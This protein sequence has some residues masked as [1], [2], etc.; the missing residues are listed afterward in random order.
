MEKYVLRCVLC[1]KEYDDDS[2]RL[3]CD[4][5]HEPSLLRTEYSKKDLSLKEDL[6][7]MF[8]FSDYLP[9]DRVL[10]CKGA[11]V[12][13]RSEGI[14]AELGLRNLHIIFNGYWPEKGAFMETASFKELE[15][16]AVLA[17]VPEGHDRTIVVAS[18]GNTGR[19]FANICS[20]NRIPLV[21][22]IPEKNA[23]Q[24]WGTEPF[25]DTVKL[26]LASGNSD[27]CD[28]ITLAG[29]LVDLNGFFAEGGALNVARRDGMATTI[30]DFATTVGAAPMHYFQAIGSGTG[31]IAAWESYLR[32]IDDGGYGDGSMKLHLSQNHPFVPITEA[33]DKGMETMPSLDPDT[34]KLQIKQTSAKVLTN[35]K[36]PYSVRGGVY[37]V[38][39]ASS[40]HTYSVTNE[41]VRNALSMFA[42]Y[43]GIDI[44]PAAGVAVGSLVQAVGR[45]LVGKDDLIALN[46]TG[47][48]ELR[49]KREY[50][51]HYLE[52]V[53]A[54]TDEEINAG[55]I[56]NKL[57]ELLA[58]V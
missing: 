42:E 51:F 17:R 15:A 10:D 20:K 24:I 18:A 38:L 32:L 41:E 58:S 56:E 43:E 12:T 11:P 54:Y 5:D 53:A 6:P 44:N 23:D 35:R 52:P 57:D 50:D 49:L 7:G 31:G 40:G 55:P 39:S 1:G 33:W 29:K 3:R 36:P 9:V 28:A 13:Y 19:A 34:A 47:G 22:V 48:G 25:S 45:K 8:K 16:P 14:G 2:F 46:I 30:L 21:L 27:Y 26:I 4:E 37:D